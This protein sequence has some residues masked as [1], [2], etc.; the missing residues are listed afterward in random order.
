[1]TTNNF[2]F[3]FAK[4]NNP[5]Q[6]TR[7]QWYRDTSPCSIPDL[8]SL[9]NR[10]SEVKILLNE[11]AKLFTSLCLATVQAQDPAPRPATLSRPIRLQEPMF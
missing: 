3:L 2:C 11:K 6:S 1:M 7:G 8:N 5:N 4:Q 10:A 9:E